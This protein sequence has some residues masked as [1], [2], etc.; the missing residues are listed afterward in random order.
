MYATLCYI[1]KHRCFSKSYQ[2][3]KEQLVQ[4]SF[5]LTDTITTFLASFAVFLPLCKLSNFTLQIK[6]AESFNIPRQT[7]QAIGSVKVLIHDNCACDAWQ[8]I[9]QLLTQSKSDL[10][11]D[12]MLK[13]FCLYLLCCLFICLFWG[14]GRGRVVYVF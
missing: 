1:C 10:K 9:I 13:D 8:V 2:P 12:R 7:T 6:T 5:L 4:R 3:P 14:Y 11:Q